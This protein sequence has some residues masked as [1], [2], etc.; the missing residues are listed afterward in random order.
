MFKMLLASKPLRSYM[1]PYANS[2]SPKFM[3]FWKHKFGTKAFFTVSKHLFCKWKV[4][5]NLTPKTG[6]TTSDM[7]S[8]SSVNSVNFQDDV[9]TEGTRTSLNVFSNSFRTNHYSIWRWFTDTIFKQM[10]ILWLRRLTR[11][12]P[13]CAIL[14]AQTRHSYNFWIWN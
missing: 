3:V 1:S 12:T 13:R 9:F 2:D 4:Q 8:F 7:S 10:K 11:L 5:W 6:D 14:L